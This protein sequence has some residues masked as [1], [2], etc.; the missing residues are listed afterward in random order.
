M[1]SIKKFTAKVAYKII[2]HVEREPHIYRNKDVDLSRSYM[3]SCLADRGFDYYK[4]RLGELSCIHRRDIITMCGVVVTLPKPLTDIDI[5]DQDQLFTEITNFLCHRY[6][7]ENMIS[8]IVHR[9]EAGEAHLHFNFVPAIEREPE[10]YNDNMLAVYAY[11]NENPTAN[12]SKVAKELGIDRKT[13]RRWRNMKGEEH[14][15][16]EKLCAAE[17]VNRKD[18]INLHPDLRTWLNKNCHINNIKNIGDYFCTGATAR[19]GGN[20]SVDE[21]KRE[22]ALRNEITTLKKQIERQQDML[23]KREDTIERLQDKIEELQ[24]TVEDQQDTIEDQ[25]D[26]I[27]DQQDTI[28]ELQNN[29]NLFTR[30]HDEEITF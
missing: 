4:K 21:L 25:Q 8:A 23:E 9:D 19:Q 7:G 20:R 3:N 28:E 1:A 13:V 15:S 11:L 12:N 24:N 27:E 30:H 6:G 29:D 5:A 18:L 10:D 17:V 16:P 14:L 26:T 22:T 2:R